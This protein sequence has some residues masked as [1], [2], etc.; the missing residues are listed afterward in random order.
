MASVTKAGLWFIF[1]KCAGT[2]LMPL[3]RL[4]LSWLRG[5]TDS[6]SSSSSS[7]QAAC[8]P[9]CKGGWEASCW[10]AREE[11]AEEFNRVAR[12]GTVG[13]DSMSSEEGELRL[14]ADPKE[15]QRNFCLWLLEEFRRVVEP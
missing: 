13:W 8:R 10:R 14:R 12:G 11:A 1:T 9:G 15:S 3:L 2:D 6:S 5:S 4:R 7:S